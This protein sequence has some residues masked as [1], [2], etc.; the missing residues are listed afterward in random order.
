MGKFLGALCKLAEK[1]SQ[2]QK[3]CINFNC[4]R[5]SPLLL[6]ASKYSTRKLKVV[7]KSLTK[8]RCCGAVGRCAGEPVSMVPV[9]AVDGEH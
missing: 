2:A 1:G 9:V 8:S 4:E 7:N 6:S 3:F 5:Y